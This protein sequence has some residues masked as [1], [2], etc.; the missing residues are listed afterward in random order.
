MDLQITR[1]QRGVERKSKKIENKRAQSSLENY[2]GNIGP[3]TPT[4]NPNKRTVQHGEEVKYMMRNKRAMSNPRA[5]VQQV[6]KEEYIPLEK[7]LHVPRPPSEYINNNINNSNNSII[8]KRAETVCSN[9]MD[10]GVGTQPGI[11]AKRTPN[12]FLGDINHLFIGGKDHSFTMTKL[13][14]LGGDVDANGAYALEGGGMGMRRNKSQNPPKVPVRGLPVHNVPDT[15]IEVY[16]IYI[17]IYRN[18]GGKQ[19]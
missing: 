6:Y 2:R 1:K 17:Y 15:R 13:P 9:L 4:H 12:Q 14:E 3:L 7:H 19:R 16:I 18:Y 10:Y 11:S 8:H 5:L